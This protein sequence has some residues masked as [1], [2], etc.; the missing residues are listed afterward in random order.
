ML[1]FYFVKGEWYRKAF[2]DYTKGDAFSTPYRT[3]ILFV[4]MFGVPIHIRS[5]DLP[6]G[7]IEKEFGDRRVKEQPK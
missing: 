1:N 5:F 7:S 6:E 2:G 3:Y 4:K